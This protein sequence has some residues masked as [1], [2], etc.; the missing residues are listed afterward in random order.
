MKPED[1]LKLPYAKMFTREADGT[2]FVEVLELPG[3]MSCGDTLEE[4]DQMIE[5]AM[6]GWIEVKLEEGVEIPV[7]YTQYRR[8]RV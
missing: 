7:P 3:C 4:A 8:C 1:Y 6:R 2:W 5:D